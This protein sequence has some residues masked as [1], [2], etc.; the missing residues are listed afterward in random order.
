MSMP[1]ARQRAMSC[2]RADRWSGVASAYRGTD[3]R[4]AR[5]VVSFGVAGLR[6]AVVVSV[7]GVLLGGMP[8]GPGRMQRRR[9][10]LVGRPRTT[11]YRE[12]ADRVWG[13]NFA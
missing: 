7:M 5:A 9:P 6:V 3:A 1:S 13:K 11:R 2:P 12:L 4:A 10:R 8:Q